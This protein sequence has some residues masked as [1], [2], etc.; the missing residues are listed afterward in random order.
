MFGALHS[1]VRKDSRRARHAAIRST[2]AKPSSRGPCTVDPERSVGKARDCVH[3][4]AGHRVQQRRAG[5][6]AHSRWP[7]STAA[8]CSRHVKAE[9]T[10]MHP[11]QA[12]KPSRRGTGISMAR[13]PADLPSYPGRPQRLRSRQPPAKPAFIPWVS[14]FGMESALGEYRDHIEHLGDLSGAIPIAVR[15]SRGI[16]LKCH[17]MLLTDRSQSYAGF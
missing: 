15:R 7:P 5:R 8:R 14:R 1:L 4:S 3:D 9:G 10:F 13:K 16:E 2:P 6:I 12:M 11:Q 17:E